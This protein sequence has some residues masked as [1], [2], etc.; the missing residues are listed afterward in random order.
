MLTGTVTSG[1]VV[2]LN[3]QS[4]G[5]ISTVKVQPGQPVHKGQAL[6]VEYAPNISAIVTA[7]DASISAVQAKIA[8]VKT[9][10]TLY[11]ATIPQD[12]AQIAAEKAQLAMDQAQLATDR[13]RTDATEIVAPAA[14][15]IVAANGQ[16]GEA[17][18]SSGIRDYSS[19]S[20][21]V[22]GAQ[23]PAFSLLP[24]GPQSTGRTQASG[25]SLPVVA[26]RVSY[27]WSSTGPEY[28]A[29]VA[30]ASTVPSPP[31]NG[32]AANIAFS[33]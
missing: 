14:G 22:A 30:I 12:Q 24:E 28:Q 9:E 31:L 25:S 18:T 8:E 16:P 27:S 13:M 3:F 32:M 4:A 23:Q 10:E 11:P 26:L 33:R 21:Q 19:S 15:V 6:A 1:G 29:I 17:V 2:T 5:V 20:Q 7:D